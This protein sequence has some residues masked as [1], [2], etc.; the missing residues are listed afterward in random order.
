MQNDPSMMSSRAWNFKCHCEWGYLQEEALLKPNSEAAKWYAELSKEYEDDFN[1]WPIIG[2]QQGFRA[3]K[4]GASMVME[5]K[6]NGEYQAFVSERLPEALDDA[7]KGRNY[8]KFREICGAL[9]P[10]ELYDSLPMCFPMTHTIT[11]NGRPIRGVERYPLLA[12]E[13]EQRHLTHLVL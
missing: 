1:M 13:A 9:T 3:Y 6:I 2:C 8:A 5:L 10:K 12:W 11:V 7:I 4:N